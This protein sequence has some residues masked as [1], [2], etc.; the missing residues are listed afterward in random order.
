MSLTEYEKLLER[1]LTLLPKKPVRHERFVLP[2]PICEV[3]GSRTYLINFKEICDTL[4]RP[5]QHFLKYLS[6]EMATAGFIDGMKAVFQGR[7]SA[8]ILETLIDRYVKEF[9]IC[10]ICRRPDTRIERE[11]R[12]S[13]LLC[14]A[15]GAKS[16]LR[17]IK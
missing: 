6:R 1:A 10:P 3:A 9:I 5:Q 16:S 14:E 15:C 11:R 17:T 8:R 12:L 13:F 7:F 2:E 4:N